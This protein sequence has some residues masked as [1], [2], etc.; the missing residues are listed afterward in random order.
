MVY[1]PVALTS[2]Y[3]HFIKKGVHSLEFQGTIHP[4]AFFLRFLIVLSLFRCT[5]KSFFENHTPSTEIPS[6]F[7]E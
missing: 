4:F 7:R 2:S 1:V 6:E 5:S 3:T